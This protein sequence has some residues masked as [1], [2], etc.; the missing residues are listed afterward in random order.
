MGCGGSKSTDTSPGASK[1]KGGVGKTEEEEDE[2]E[3]DYLR[4]P[5]SDPVR[6]IYIKWLSRDKNYP[7][8][9][10]KMFNY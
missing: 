9:I 6:S 5:E 8:S 1:K 3:E 7:E 2:E 4:E 10:L